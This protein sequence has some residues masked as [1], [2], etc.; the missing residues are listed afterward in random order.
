M[1]GKIKR[2]IYP[3]VEQ[4]KKSSPVSDRDRRYRVSGAYKTHGGILVGSNLILCR[5]QR[6]SEIR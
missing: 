4:V 2:S 6:L 5:R 3:C 1:S